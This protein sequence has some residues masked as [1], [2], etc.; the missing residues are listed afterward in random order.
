MYT[1]LTKALFEF[2]ERLVTEVSE[3]QQIIPRHCSQLLKACYPVP[4]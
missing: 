1:P 2:L 4:L 3:M